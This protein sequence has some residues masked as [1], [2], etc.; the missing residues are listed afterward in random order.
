LI[1]LRFWCLLGVRTIK[2]GRQCNIHQGVNFMQLRHSRLESPEGTLLQLRLLGPMHVHINAEE[3]FLAARKSRALLAYLA[4]RRGTQVPRQTLMGL[5]WGN[6]SE[7]QAR[8]SLRQTLSALRKELGPLSEE[9]LITS[10]ESIS[11]ET[12]GVWV[13]VDALDAALH[14]PAAANLESVTSLFRGDLLEGLTLSEAAFDQWLL[15][16]R[17]RARSQML[18]VWSALVKEQEQGN[19]IEDAITNCAKALA[20]DPF[21]EGMHRLLIGLYMKQGRQDA[22]LAQFEQ[23]RR[24]L[25]D[26]LNAMPEQATLELLA[27]VKRRRLQSTTP[28]TPRPRPTVGHGMVP[29][30]LST[31]SMPALPDQPSIAV[32]PFTNMSSEPEQEFFSDGI[33]ED[34]ITELGRYRELFVIARN[35]SFAFKHA[36]IDSREVGHTLGVRYLLE[37]SV[38]KVGNRIR[39]TAQ[40]VDT[41]QATQVWADRYD[42]D[43]I[44]LFDLQDELTRS[45]VS[46]VKGR[47]DATV[48]D[49]ATRKPIEN[50]TAYECVIRGQA[51]IHQFTQGSL[52]EARVLLESAVALDPGMARALGWLAYVEA[53]ESLYWEMSAANLDC[54]IHL[55]E[56]GL[57]LD[58]NDSRCHLAL[59]LACLFRQAFEKARHHLAKASSLNPN[60][61][62]SM[63]E[64]GRFKMY[65]NEALEGA[66]HVRRA[67]RQN[68][69]HPNWYWN[70]LARCLHTAKQ[71]HGA[72]SA[73]EQLETLHYWHHAYFAACNAELGRVELAR[74]HVARVLALKPDFSIAQFKLVHPYRD[75]LVLDEF[76]D[77]YHKAG[78]PS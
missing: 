28:A 75:R 58:A 33:S 74:N 22:A 60:D 46:T 66:E 13:D 10:N 64:W 5:L 36:V 68:P 76:F 48:V 49:R 24:T 6:R 70:V 25:A 35:S 38:R 45:I 67:L 31:P 7:D 34:I 14:K 44:D 32:L 57:A 2:V 17:E 51:L 47:V 1:N 18:R 73:L 65:T 30:S 26:Q 23:C 69:F 50:L 40:L 15:A 4:L 29:N 52:A 20:L 59:G 63:I 43:V 19:R 77:G 37:G 41:V 55:A 9:F 16:E 27:E 54:A 56:Q 8:A 3:A 21:Q 72:I 42:R 61:D 11:L 12:T 71:Y 62:L 78:L 39:V 53:Y